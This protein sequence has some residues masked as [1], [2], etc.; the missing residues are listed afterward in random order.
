MAQAVETCFTSVKPCVKTPVP[1]QIKNVYKYS[2]VKTF[3][4]QK[5]SKN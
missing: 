1:P 4:K 2:D 3:I 5:E